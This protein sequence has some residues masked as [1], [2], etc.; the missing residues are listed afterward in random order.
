VIQD[1]LDRLV[2]L[3][4]VP[5]RIEQRMEASRKADTSGTRA[6]TRKLRGATGWEPGYTLDRTL[7]DV[8]ADWRGRGV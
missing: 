8:L 1:I 4:G 3:S 6:D 7:V 5:V 2:S